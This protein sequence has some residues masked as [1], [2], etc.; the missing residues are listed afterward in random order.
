MK[1]KIIYK[2]FAATLLALIWSAC[3]KIDEPLTVEEQDINL[4][5]L[6]FDSVVVTR[7]QVLLEDFTGH[8]C[9][10][11]PEAAINAHNLAEENDHKLIIYGVHAG[12]YAEPDATGKYTTDFQC[13]AGNEIFNN[14]VITGWPAGTVDR[15][16]YGGNA[17]LGGGAWED[18]VNEQL[19]LENVINMTLKNY[20]N[21]EE[22]E[23]TVEVLTTF[24]QALEGK[25][26][27]AVLLA[28]DHILS[29]QRNN[30]PAIGPTPDWENY[31]QRNV[32]RGSISS[33]TFGNYLTENDGTIVTDTT[34]KTR[35]SYELNEEWVAENCNVIAY[36]IHE[37][38]G[39][40]L[41]VAEL[42]I[43]IE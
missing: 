11:C 40:I 18:A 37:E 28:E 6:P 17:I 9:V 41:Q 14:F 32:L 39:E 7:K 16:E 43:D 12:F 30:E 3:D 29:W 26:K 36:I 38:T 10:N 27:L 42:G 15:V 4:N 25:Y 5:A 34:Y 8:K 2:I 22:N 20:Y 24:L 33:S 1:R 13:D 21:L 23:L 31:E 19:Q 35:L